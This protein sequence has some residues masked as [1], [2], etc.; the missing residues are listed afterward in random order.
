[1]HAY[2]GRPAITLDHVHSRVYDNSYN[3]FLLTWI[4]NV[5]VRRLEIL[6]QPALISSS[7]IELRSAVVPDRDAATGVVHHIQ[8]DRCVEQFSLGATLYNDIAPWIDHHRVAAKRV[9][10]I[11]ADAI[12]GDHI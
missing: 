7:S 1:M 9:R 12:A 4:G 8:V 2:A 6:D 5:I 10:S 11:G 3:Q